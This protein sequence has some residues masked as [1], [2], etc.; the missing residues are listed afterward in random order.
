M[1]E[2]DLASVPVI[3]VEVTKQHTPPKS[4]I[5]DKE[6]IEALKKE[7]MEGKLWRSSKAIAEKLNIDVI[8]LDTYL[9]AQPALVS[10]PSTTEGLMLYASL[11]RIDAAQQ[12]AKT[13]PKVDAVMRP[14]AAEED[15]YA[16]SAIHSSF[17]LLQS[18]LEKYALRIH[19]L[20]PEAFTNLVSGKDK[21]EAGFVLLATKLK[22]DTSKLP[23]V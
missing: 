20:N 12:A 17:I 3:D 7:F 8:E 16:L 21:V 10:R 19:Q 14:V 22:A 5:E 2:E 1:T 15:R 23:K 13:D 18:A 4:K 9:R 11:S 6:F